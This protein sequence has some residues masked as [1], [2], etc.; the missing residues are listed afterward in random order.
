M[1]GNMQWQTQLTEVYG[2]EDT[3]ASE[4]ERDGGGKLESK[5]ET[6]KKKKKTVV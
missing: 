4:R 1:S 2:Q 6:E 3:R 5:K